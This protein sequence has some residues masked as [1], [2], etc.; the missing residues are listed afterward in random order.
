M[1]SLEAATLFGV[2][3][4]VA[5][6]TGGGTGIGLMMAKA[7]EENGAKVYIIGRRLETLEKAAKQAKHG[8]IIPAQGDVTKKED[9]DRIV[10]SITKSDGFINVLV[11]NSGIGGPN[12]LGLPKDPTLSQYREYMYNVNIDDFTNTFHV[13]TSA[14]FFCIMAFLELL[15]A[16]NKKGNVQ[17]K[18][19]VIATSSIGGFN[20]LPLAGFAY[21]ATK[22]GTT[23]MMK[24]LATAFV[25]YGIRSNIIAPGLYPSELADELL[26]KLETSGGM[27]K[28]FVPEQRAGSIEDMGGAI[29][30]LTSRA[31]GYLNGNVLVTDGGRLG[32]VPSS[33]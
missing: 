25:P 29:L 22:I 18:S 4:L 9:L 27:P 32:V 12:L 10:D 5:V 15:N 3:G 16:G 2:K 26:V 19:Q 17:Q 7:L 21:A 28:S 1:S 23:F 14:V 13:N 33:Y 6:I 24:A 30:F 11:A 8:N 20:R 31:G